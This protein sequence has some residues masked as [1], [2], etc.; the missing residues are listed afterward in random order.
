MQV[1]WDLCHWGVPDR[2]D[3][4]SAE[5]VTRFAAFAAAAVGVI[6][7]RRSGAAAPFPDLFC[8][9]NEISFWAWIGGDKEHFY[10]FRRGEGAVLKRQLVRA[11]LAAIRAVR[12]LDA[13]ARFLQ[14]E[15]IIHISPDPAK[16]NGVGDVERYNASQYE[17]WDMLTGHREPELGG[18]PEALDVIG[19]NYYW[20]NQWIDE[21]APTPPGH[22]QHRP[23]HL[24]L[25]D[26][27]HRYHRPIIITE[28]GI[29]G[30]A[31][32]GWLAYVAAEA[33]Q[34]QR[35]GVLLLGI[36]LYPVMDYPGWDNGRHCPCGLIEV[37]P[38]WTA[39]SL[40]RDLAS[41][42]RTQQKLLAT[43]S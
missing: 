8:P 14:P 28:T 3:I 41:E 20:N 29:E 27:W 11:S 35:L 40:R 22:P 25:H 19:V 13:E 18:W 4:F 21:G 43:T 30:H 5:F 7:E 9:I 10:P 16:P 37:G 33:R 26:V 6:R 12:E 15:P 17:A 38:D 32:A 42:L 36:C 1:L 39:R 31:E 34:A 24:M 23:L 2:L